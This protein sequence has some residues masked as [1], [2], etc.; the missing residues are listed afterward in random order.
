[1]IYEKKGRKKIEDMSAR[2]LSQ[3]MKY[4]G[5]IYRRAKKR[6]DLRGSESTGRMD[7]YDRQLI[8]LIDRTLQDCSHQNSMILR[9]TY[10]ENSDEGWYAEFL[11]ASAFYR[12]KKEAAVEFLNCLD[13]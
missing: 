11:S 1:M 13:Y 5:S 12:L 2:E 10:F 9:R 8:Y 4:L 7:Q 3:I 6:A